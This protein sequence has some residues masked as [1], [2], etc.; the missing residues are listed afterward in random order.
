MAE[1][2]NDDQIIIELKQRKSSGK[3][4]ADDSHFGGPFPPL[5]TK[6]LQKAEDQLDAVTK[7]LIAS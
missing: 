5:S 7:V 3:L 1:T 4:C 2:L 6:A